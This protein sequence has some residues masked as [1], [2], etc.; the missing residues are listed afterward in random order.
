MSCCGREKKERQEGEGECVRSKKVQGIVSSHKGN[1][2]QE[3][4]KTSTKRQ[5]A[6]KLNSL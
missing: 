4:V 1:R 3:R 2:A 6:K 5:T